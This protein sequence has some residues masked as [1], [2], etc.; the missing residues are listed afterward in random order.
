M[1]TPLRTLR[2]HESCGKVEMTLMTDR[3]IGEYAAERSHGCR[4]IVV[5]NSRRVLQCLIP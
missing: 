3:I 2:K 5:E 1:T 4:A